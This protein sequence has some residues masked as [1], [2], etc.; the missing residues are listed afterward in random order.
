MHGLAEIREMNE[1]PHE[2]RLDD[3]MF[4]GRHRDH[5]RA[6][7]NGSQ[8]ESADE[9]E[10]AEIDINDIF[11]G[12]LIA[13]MGGSALSIL[14]QKA[15]RDTLN[16]PLMKFWDKLNRQR[17][18]AGRPEALYKEARE[19]FNG[20]P[21]PAGAL[22]FVGDDGIRAIPATPYGGRAAYHGEF[23]EDLADGSTMWRTVHSHSGAICYTT[24]EAALK[25]AKLA[26][27]HA[28]ARNS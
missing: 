14:R 15:K 27:C 12:L 10:H 13:G 17:L 4:G 22:T 5:D 20:G 9:A 3:T 6:K 24:A 18:N 26:Q 11:A 2:P 1:N 25:G 7:I 19:I 23:R 21:T 28:E 16:S 8:E